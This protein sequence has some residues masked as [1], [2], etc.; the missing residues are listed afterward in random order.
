MALALPGVHIASLEVDPVHMVI[1][2][3]VVLHGGLAGTIDV[4]T[5]HSKDLLPRILKRYNGDLKFGAAFMD[6]KGSRYQEDMLKMES[7]G[8]LHPGAVIVADNVLKPGDARL[9][10]RTSTSAARQPGWKN[11]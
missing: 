11:R 9:N 4:W 6:Q 5:G 7:E 1:A 2:R 8:L 3:N 10:G